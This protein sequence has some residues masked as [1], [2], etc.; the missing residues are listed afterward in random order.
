M[1]PINFAILKHPMNWITV[2]LM[3]II[4]MSVVHLLQRHW[5]NN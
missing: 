3:T 5:D 4:A 2:M 1:V